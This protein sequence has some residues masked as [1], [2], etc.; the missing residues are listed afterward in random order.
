MNH[1]HFFFLLLR[2]RFKFLQDNFSQVLKHWNVDSANKKVCVRGRGAHP[3]CKNILNS[4]I[5]FF[6]YIMHY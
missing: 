6:F 3:N 2:I 5:Y 1:F 4:G